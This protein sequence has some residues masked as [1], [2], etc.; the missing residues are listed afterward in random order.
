TLTVTPSAYLVFRRSA[1]LGDDH[2]RAAVELARFLAAKSEAWLVEAVGL[3]PA[4][5]ASW[6]VWHQRSP[7]NDTTRRILSEASR[8]AAVAWPPADEAANLRAALQPL[9]QTFANGGASPEQFAASLRSL[10]ERLRQPSGSP[11]RPARRPHRAPTAERMR[12][13][14]SSSSCSPL[15]SPSASVSAASS[16]STSISFGVMMRSPIKGCS[17]CSSTSRLTGGG[18][19]DPG[20]AKPAPNAPAPGSGAGRGN[21]PPAASRSRPSLTTV[22]ACTTVG[23]PMASTGT[24]SVARVMP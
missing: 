17:T 11:R 14:K 21:P 18:I 22:V 13:F 10:L 23:T 15:S 9:W 6:E 8:A 16:T 20:G 7:W 19:G 2:T 4:S 12:R 3:L 5:E 24:P 1:Y